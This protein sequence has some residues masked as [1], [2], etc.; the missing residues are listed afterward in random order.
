MEA[1]R[2][3][4]TSLTLA[5]Q[6]LADARPGEDEPV[7]TAEW[8]FNWCSPRHEGDFWTRPDRGGPETELRTPHKDPG[9]VRNPTDSHPEI[10]VEPDVE[11]LMLNSGAVSLANSAPDAVS[12][13]NLALL[14]GHSRNGES[15]SSQF[16]D[17]NTCGN[18]QYAHGRGPTIPNSH[19]QNHTDAHRP[20]ASA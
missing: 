3:W 19:H 9:A 17:S 2:A 20:C 6:K 13:Q 15:H 18:A 16:R 11:E 5:R 1:A 4:F 8:D 7:I 12:K 14:D 10:N